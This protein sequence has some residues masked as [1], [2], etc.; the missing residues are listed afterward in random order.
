MGISRKL[1]TP[2]PVAIEKHILALGAQQPV[3]NRTQ[4]FSQFTREIVEGLGYVFQTSG[5]TAVLTGSGTAAMEA[6]VLNFLDKSDRVLIINGGTFGQRW[7]DLCRTHSINYSEFKVKVGEDVDPD[8]LAQ[9]LLQ[10]K[11]TALLINAHETSSGQLYDI[12][13]IGKMARKSGLLFVVDA[14]SSICA[15]RFLMDDWH[16][17]VA[18]LSS[19]KALALPPGL[20][21]VAMST[22]AQSLLKSRAPETL[23]FN[24]QNYLIN[25]QRG[26]SPYTPA[27]G[28]YLQLHQRLRDIRQETIEAIVG[29]HHERAVQFRNSIADLGFDTLPACP[30]NA[31]T[32]VVCKNN[33]AFEIVQILRDDFLIDVAPSGGDMKHIIFRVSHMGAIKNQDADLLISALR[34]IVM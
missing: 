31:L 15:D 21:F 30:S 29:Q 22:R 11:F 2:G 1:F 13:T 33:N 10:A 12:E 14:V 5:E 7:C 26:Q 16:V 32:A 24:L 8:L 25:Q 3:Y 34:Q 4:E 27:I 28:I 17:D 18:I 19:H 20:A 9:M 6:A 23:Y